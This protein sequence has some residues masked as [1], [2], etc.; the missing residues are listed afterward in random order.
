LKKF[1][2]YPIVV[3]LTLLA[4]SCATSIPVT[5]MKPSDIDTTGIKK[6][7][8]LPFGFAGESTTA[9]PLEAAFNRYSSA[10]RWRTRLEQQV[11]SMLTDGVTDALMKSGAF[12]I[13]GASEVSRYVTSGQNPAAVVDGYVIGEVSFLAPDSRSGYEDVKGSDGIV[14]STYVVHK[15]MTLEY[16]VKVFR[17]S[18]GVLMGHTRQSG[19]TEAVAYGDNAHTT[20]TSDYDMAKT[21]INS[22]FYAVAK[23]I[24]PYQVTEYRT[25]ATDET[26]NELMK[27]ADELV[28]KKMYAEALKIYRNVYA[29]DKNF[30]AAFNA[31]ILV[32]I[33]GDMPGAIREMEALAQETQ[34]SR[35][36]NELARMKQTLADEERLRAGK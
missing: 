6:I 12:S 26:K 14:R 11:S 2:A 22:T 33:S 17:A 25:L 21:I 24:A 5:L 34:D 19:K 8:V 15:T 10:Y 13:V 3:A 35:A 27:Q 1:H 4:F 30:A 36:V 28:E 18:D 31:A 20:V 23:S 32:E 16:S 7:A 9:D 29:A